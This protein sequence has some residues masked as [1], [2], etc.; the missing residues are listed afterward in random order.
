MYLLV[1][2]QTNDWKVEEIVGIYKIYNNDGPS[3]KRVMVK[4]TNQEYVI[5]LNDTNKYHDL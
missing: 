1:A 3:A 4:L 5:I 2:E